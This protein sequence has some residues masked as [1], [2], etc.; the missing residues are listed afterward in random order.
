MYPPPPP[1]PPTHALHVLQK[2]GERAVPTR[3]QILIVQVDVHRWHR[4][5]VAFG[6]GERV[7]DPDVDGGRDQVAQTGAGEQ[8]K[9]VEDLTFD[10]R[11]CQCV[12]RG[13]CCSVRSKGARRAMQPGERTQP[14]QVDGRAAAAAVV[15]G[16]ASE[17][18]EAWSIPGT[19]SRPDKEGGWGVDG[20]GKE[21]WG[22]ASTRSVLQVVSLSNHPPQV[23]VHLLHSWRKRDQ[24]RLCVE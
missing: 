16:G 5:P 4:R 22:G 12:H 11:A 20:W 13:G 1:P 15:V 8:G 7:V 23:S 18:R 14:G 3:Q 6:G 9:V 17:L 10:V 24:R 2:R 19:A 21:G